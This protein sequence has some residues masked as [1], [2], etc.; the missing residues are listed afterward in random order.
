[1]ELLRQVLLT[2]EAD[3]QSLSVDRVEGGWIASSA[4]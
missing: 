1:M 3:R 2:I 4:A